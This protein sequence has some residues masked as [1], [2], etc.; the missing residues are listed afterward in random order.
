MKI[1]NLFDFQLHHDYYEVDDLTTFLKHVRLLMPLINQLENIT[2]FIKDTQAKYLLANN[3]LI[4][5][6]HQTELSA[7]IGKTAEE[8]F[9]DELGSAF[10]QQD[11]DVMNNQP[12]ISHLELHLYQSG[13]PGWCMATKI[14]LLNS[15]QQVI[16]MI[17]IAIDLQ[18][19]KEN[20]PKLNSK[21]SLVAQ[22][23]SQNLNQ[24]IA[25]DELAHIADLS[26]SQLNRQ[27]KHI[28]HMSPMQLV[29]KKR[30]ELAITLLANHHSITDIS[31][32]CGY[33]DHSAFSRKFKEI[34][35]LTPSQ[36]RKKLHAQAALWQ[37]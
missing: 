11:L 33:T 7:L 19:P 5:R 35:N 25:I 26:V 27:F 4:E 15:S 29:N 32:Q 17:G 20:R 31:V 37:K 8:I 24:P 2:F 13:F 23:I 3:N 6:A 21:L 10:T 28:F 34:T 1:D 16:G 22:Y 9:G 12:L 18:E 30:F 36:F 14:P